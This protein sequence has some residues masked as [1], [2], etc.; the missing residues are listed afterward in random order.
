MEGCSDGEEK[1]T[2]SSEGGYGR[3]RKW[4]NG[5]WRF[6]APLVKGGRVNAR[7]RR[8]ISRTVKQMFEQ[9]ERKVGK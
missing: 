9:E 3:D 5:G 4:E 7:Y 6:R 2:S 1:E 8:K